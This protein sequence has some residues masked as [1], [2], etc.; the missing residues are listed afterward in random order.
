MTLL[1]NTYSSVLESKYNR[2]SH[3]SFSDVDPQMKTMVEVDV[4]FSEDDVQRMLV[5]IHLLVDI[6]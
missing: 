1:Q 2:V 5:H 4:D 6:R 3:S